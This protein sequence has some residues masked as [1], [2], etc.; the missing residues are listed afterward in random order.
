M[1]PQVKRLE[2]AL[3]CFSRYYLLSINMPY[4]E[5]NI[6]EFLRNINA[7][8]LIKISKGLKEETLLYDIWQ[9]FES[10]NIEE[11]EEIRIKTKIHIEN[12]IREKSYAR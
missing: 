6:L 9:I 3:I 5:K 7:K 10:Y 12:N 1:V 8:T 11:L 2:E 4:R